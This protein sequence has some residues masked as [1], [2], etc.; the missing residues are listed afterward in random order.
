[1]CR[2]CR[3]NAAVQGV[4]ARVELVQ[5]RAER[6]AL[7]AGALVHIDPDRRSRGERRARQ[8]AG[9]VPG[10]DFLQALARSVRAGAIKLGPASDFATHWNTPGLEI[11]LV[12]LD[13]ECKEATVW[14]GALAGVRRRA[15]RL[16]EGATWTDC[17]GSAAAVIAVRP[18]VPGSWVFDPD[19]AL[20]RAGLLDSFAAAHGLARCAGGVDYLTGPAGLATPFLAAFE[21]DDVVSLDR[22][23][24]RRLVADRRLGPLEIKVRGLGLRPE[25]LRQRLQPTGP[26][27]ATLLCYG[28]PGPARAV[29]ARRPPLSPR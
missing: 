29:L 9:Y 13:G 8:L 10:L 14:F 22:K 24:L 28:G 18:P 23:V 17:D 3:W 16:P 21:V 7:P 2:R 20:V 6:F 1:M 26:C 27:P 4:A 5:S 12:S 11:E 25:V 19:P 15:T